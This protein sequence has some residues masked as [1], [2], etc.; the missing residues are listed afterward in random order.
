[1][2]DRKAYFKER[3]K[4]PENK[5]YQRRAQQLWRDRHPDK[6]VAMSQR[7]RDKHKDHF[8]SVA[9]KRLKRER[10]SLNDYYVRFLIYIQTDKILKP[11][12]IPKEIVEA[13]RL[14]LLTKRKLKTAI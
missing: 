3:R 11:K 12:D 13:H 4:L 5:E 1:M 2:K 8:N 10:D 7:N 9:K 14:I 6:S